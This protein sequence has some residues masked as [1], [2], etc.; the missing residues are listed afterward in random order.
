MAEYQAAERAQGDTTGLH[1]DL[2]DAVRDRVGQ[3]LAAGV[4]PAS[5]Q[6]APVITAFLAR[7]AHV[8]GRPDDA[9]LQRWRL[10]R[11]ETANDLRVER[12]WQAHPGGRRSCSYP[13]LTGPRSESGTCGRG[14]VELHWHHRGVG[15]T[16]KS[17]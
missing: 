7:Y 16:T 3:A 14:A 17:A 5:P 10:T 2:T 11:L 13:A 9:N 8:F 6:A 1:H 4:A 12:Y 15:A